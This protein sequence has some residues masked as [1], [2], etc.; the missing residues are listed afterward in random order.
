MFANDIALAGSE[1]AL[2]AN[3]SAYMLSSPANVTYVTSRR[4]M[5]THRTIH[6]VAGMGVYCV[7]SVAMR[8]VGIALGTWTG[9]LPLYGNWARLKG[10]PEMLVEGKSESVGMNGTDGSTEY[11]SGHH[12]GH[13]VCVCL[14]QSTLGDD[15]RVHWRME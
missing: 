7:P 15:E 13:Q 12:I 6:V 2:I 14:Q 5:L 8:F 10:S 9:W 4:G 11:W 1:L 3:L